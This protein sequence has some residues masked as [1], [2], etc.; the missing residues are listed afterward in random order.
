MKGFIK[1]LLSVLIIGFAVAAEA[2]TQFPLR[3][4]IDVSTRRNTRNIGAGSDGQ[5]RV[6]NVSL[7]VRIRRSSGSPHSDPLSVEV[8]VIGRQTHTG[9]YGIVDVVKKD[10]NFAEERLFEF[11]SREYSL[12]RTSGNINV[13]GTYET[14]LVV[15]TNE[16]GEVL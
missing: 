16:K 2:Q 8:Y 13:G 3:M 6:E 11:T 9:Y 1:G 14:F 7:R 12:G 4:D 15:V 10:F 5:A